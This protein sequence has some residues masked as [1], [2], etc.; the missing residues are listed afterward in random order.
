MHSDRTR[1]AHTRRTRRTW[2]SADPHLL[3]ERIIGYTHRPFTSLEEM[4]RIL[5]ATWNARVAPD[6][7]VYLL[8]DGAL[9]RIDESLP[10]LGELAGEKILIAGNHD[11]CWEGADRPERWIDQSHAVG[12]T[13]ILPTG[14]LPVD[15]AGG[16]RDVTLCHFPRG[17]ESQPGR[18]DRYQEWRPFGDGWMFCGHVHDAWQAGGHQVDVGVAVWNYAPVALGT[19]GALKQRIE[20]S[21]E[22]L[23]GLHVA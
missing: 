2:L 11:R 3:H 19:L 7:L 16:P 10:L 9:G 22:R 17:R 8:G 6:D 14:Q 12:F 20:A 21:E 1:S 15:T 23:R 18:A 4:T 5:T 13:Q